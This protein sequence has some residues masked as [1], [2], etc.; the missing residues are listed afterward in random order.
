MKSRLVWLITRICTGTKAGTF[1]VVVMLYSVGINHLVVTVLLILCSRVA[2]THPAGHKPLLRVVR[3][4]SHLTL[5]CYVVGILE[6]RR[7]L[8]HRLLHTKLG[9][10]VRL[11]WRYLGLCVVYLLSLLRW[12]RL[13]VMLNLANCRL[14]ARRLTDILSLVEIVRIGRFGQFRV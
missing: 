5:V 4:Q 9:H 11:P 2:V 1:L 10:H 14:V 3:W 12:L 7:L 8:L 13:M 6:A